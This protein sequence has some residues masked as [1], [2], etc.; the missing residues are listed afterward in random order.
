MGSN[1]PAFQSSTMDA[2]DSHFPDTQQVPHERSIGEII[3]QANNLSAEQI[4]QILSYQ[5]DNGVRFGEAAVALGSSTTP[6]RPSRPR[7]CRPSWWWPPSP[8]PSKPKPS[9]PCAA[10]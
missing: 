1:N 8:S 5:K 3:S 9:G 10:T 4:Q 2:R 6:T 7:T